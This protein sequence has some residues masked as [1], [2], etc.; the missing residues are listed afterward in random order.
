MRL[1]GLKTSLMVLLIL[2]AV[3]GM[4][5]ELPNVDPKREGFDAERLEKLTKLMED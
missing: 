1:M 2:W 5:R 4:A 3:T